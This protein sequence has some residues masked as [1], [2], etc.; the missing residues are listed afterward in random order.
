MKQI[1]EWF[2]KEKYGVI[3]TLAIIL[4]VGIVYFG[5]EGNIAGMDESAKEFGAVEASSNKVFIKM[6]E[7]EPKLFV[8][9]QKN[10]NS[11]QLKLSEGTFDNYEEHTIVGN[12]YYPIII[13]FEEANAMKKEGIFKNL[14]DSFEKFG[15]RFIVIGIM[16]KTD[17]IFDWAHF[18]PLRENQLE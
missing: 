6:A 17:S 8:E 15:Q 13:G 3:F 4:I 14:G 11:T 1:K 2:S 12:K 18:V 10:T 9:Y 16:Q 7:K 5:I